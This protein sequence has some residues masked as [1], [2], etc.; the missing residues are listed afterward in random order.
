MN[1]T[2]SYRGDKTFEAK[3][4]ASSFLL[5]CK[6]ITPVEYFAA[7]LIGCTGIDVVTFAEKDGYAVRN[8]EVRAEIERRMRVPM[9][10]ASV[11]IIYR[12]EG[13]FDAAKAK[14]YV[15]SSLESYCTTVNSVRD[16]VKIY[17]TIVFNGETVARKES[18]RSGEG[19][20]EAVFDDGFG[21]ACCS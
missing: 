18:I 14:R 3:T 21:G 5:D 20:M 1:V 16:S 19:G 17:Y 13:S 10:F 8:Y 4:A 12:F 15:L 9:K 7:G 2:L 11:H 6:K